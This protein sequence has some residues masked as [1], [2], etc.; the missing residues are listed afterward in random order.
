[1]NTLQSEIDNIITNKKKLDI[2]QYNNVI[3]QCVDNREYSATIYVYDHLIKTLGRAN[4][5]TFQH[6]NRLHS[7]NFSRK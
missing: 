5:I 7:K 2:N 3:K 6:I 1:M 4:K